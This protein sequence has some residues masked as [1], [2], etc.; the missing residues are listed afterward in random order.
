MRAMRQLAFGEPM[1][2]SEIDP[3]EAG[4]GETLVR[5]TRASVNPLDIWTSRGTTGATLP[6]TLGVEGA[7]VTAD[8]DRVFFRGVGLG[9]VRDGSYA[10]QVAAPDESI[11]PIPDGVSDADA[12]AI[13]VGGVTALDILDVGGVTAGTRVLV[14]GASGGVGTF[15]CQLARSRGA[16]VVAQTGS[17]ERGR[18]LEELA[19]TVVVADPEGLEAAVGERVDVVLDPLS[20]PFTA[21]AVRLLDPGGCVVVFGAS[22]GREITVVSTEL[23][24]NRRRLLGYGGT[25]EQP[26]DLARKA[27]LMLDEVAAGHVRAFIGGELPLEEANEAHRRILA[28]EAGG[29]L[30]LVP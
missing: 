14:L 2:L 8:G 30:L 18:A 20:G 21:P 27:A 13:G 15:A 9:I 4:P 12:A 7:G 3:P 5:V 23:Y 6:R 19:D 1:V 17:P 22:A 16:Y 11:T 24:R 29:K 10:E 26:A 25:G 28:R